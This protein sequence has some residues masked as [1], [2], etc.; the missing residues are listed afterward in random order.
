MKSPPYVYAILDGARNR[1]IQ[2]LLKRLW[3]RHYCLF[4]GELDYSLT[5]A[6]PYMMRLEED[7]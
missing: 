4:D 6:A 1:K 5:L 2:P 3:R 7:A